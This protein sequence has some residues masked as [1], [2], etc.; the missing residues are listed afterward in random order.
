MYIMIN[1]VYNHTN[2]YMSQFLYVSLVREN[3]NGSGKSQGILITCV[4][5]NPDEGLTG[6]DYCFSND[7]HSLHLK[8]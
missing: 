8:I 3:G 2:T 4:S 1:K 7:T 5:G 6:S